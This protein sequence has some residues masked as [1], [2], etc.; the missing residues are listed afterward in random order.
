MKTIVNKTFK[1]LKIRLPGGKTLY[2]GPMKSGQ[3]S[4]QAA[5]EESLR[6]LVQAG[7]VEIQGEAAHATGAGGS[8]GAV[9]EATHGHPP[10]TVVLPKG[11]R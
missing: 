7:E 1:P 5:E 4:D 8:T 2:L 9:P 10:T 11:N 6:K 3:I